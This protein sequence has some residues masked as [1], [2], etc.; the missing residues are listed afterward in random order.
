[1]VKKLGLNYIEIALSLSCKFIV[2]ICLKSRLRKKLSGPAALVL[3]VLVIF[4]YF[5][6]MIRLSGKY[7]G[8]DSPAT[9]QR[10]WSSCWRRGTGWRNSCSS[11]GTGSTARSWT[12]SCD[13]LS[14]RN[15]AHGSPSFRWARMK[16]ARLRC[17][18]VRVTFASI[19]VFKCTLNVL[20]GFLFIQYR[21]IMP[22]FL[23][24]VA[25]VVL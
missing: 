19:P 15:S 2:Q 21:Y 25:A 6:T 1:M 11:W 20:T 5:V 23:P 9:G 8:I 4:P 10:G 24:I 7:S 3:A 16:L 13:Q 12:G 22:N 17:G 18:D 14:W